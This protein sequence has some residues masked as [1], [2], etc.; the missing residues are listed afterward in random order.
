MKYTPAGGKVEVSLTREGDR[1][2]IAVHDTGPGIAPADV[3]RV[4]QPFV[5]LDTA[6]ADAPDG[7]GL[8]LSIARSIVA[9]HGGELTVE[10]TPGAGSTFVIRLPLAS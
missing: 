8:G 6:R 1:A 9:A 10:T 7:A 4:F 3:E 5:R 2:V